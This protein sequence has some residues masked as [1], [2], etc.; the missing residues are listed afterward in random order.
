MLDLVEVGFSSVSRAVTLKT[1]R[2]G[3]PALELLKTFT[4]DLVVL[5]IMMADMD[6]LEVLARLRKDPRTAAIPVLVVSGYK[7]AAK[8]AVQRGANDFCLKPFRVADVV[9]KIE[10]LLFQDQ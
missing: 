2:G 6:G 10:A 7:E 8:T 1:A 3:V 4:P 5:D 9:K